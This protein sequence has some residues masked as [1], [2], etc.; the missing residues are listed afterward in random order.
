MSFTWLGVLVLSNVFVTTRE[1]RNRS[2]SSEQ[3]ASVSISQLTPGPSKLPVRDAATS[4]PIDAWATLEQR[5]I[6]GRFFIKPYLRQSLKDP[7]SL[8]DFEVI[9]ARPNKKLKGSYKVVF[10]RARNS[11]GALVREQ[12]TVVMVYNPKDENHPWVMLP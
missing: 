6:G 1:A 9:D 11:F 10:Y 7:D 5:D 4:P 3:I 12:R 2:A 8:Q